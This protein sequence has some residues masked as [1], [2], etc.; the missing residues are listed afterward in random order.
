MM[1]SNQTNIYGVFYWV[2]I[3]A[4]FIMPGAVLAGEKVYAEIKVTF[5]DLHQDIEAV[6][7]MCEAFEAK[8]VN[9]GIAGDGSITIK[10]PESNGVIHRIE[11]PLYKGIMA[12]NIKSAHCYYRFR[13][14]S[15]RTF[16]DPD[17]PN[18]YRFIHNIADKV[19]TKKPP[20]FYSL[21]TN[22]SYK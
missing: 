5:Q 16:F 12:N 3:V 6:R 10:P 15:E 17:A 1:N 22:Y 11:I 4:V 14:R 2:W 9:R 18:N 13:D 20:T 8:S 7:V 21:S 19:A